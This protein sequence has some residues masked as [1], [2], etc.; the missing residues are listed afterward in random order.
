MLK[1]ILK[2]TAWF[3]GLILVL[4]GLGLGILYLRQDQIRDL[5]F[6]SLNESL[7]TR[8]EVQQAGA[9][10]QKF[11]NAAI[12]LDGVWAE[13]SNGLSDTLFFVKHLYVEFGILDMF[14]NEI[15]LKSISLEKGRVLLRQQGDLNNWSIL[16]SDNES[17]SASLKLEAVKLS[18]IA[19]AYQNEQV[20]L[21]GQVQKLGAKG[22]FQTGQFR[23]N[24]D[25]QSQLKRLSLGTETWLKNPLIVD[26]EM[27][28]SAKDS[29]KI[30]ARNL[31]LGTL[32]NLQAEFNIADKSTMSFQ[33]P[34]LD[35]MELKN[36]Y[37]IL[38]LNWPEHLKLAGY[39][40]LKVDLIKAP[41][42]DLRTE[43]FA[44]VQDLEL[45]YED[46][47][48]T[49]LEGQ[50]EYYRQGPF[51]RLE[52]RELFQN[53][54]G[55]ELKGT[56]RQLQKPNIKLSLHLDEQAEFWN[57]FLPK[58]WEA[59][60]GQT[61]VDLN[62]EG[63]FNSW[64]A[65][66]SRAI[67]QAHFAG[68]LKCENLKLVYQDQEQFRDLFLE[69]NLKDQRL[70]IDSLFL[71]RGQSD[72]NLKG[73]LLDIWTYL[74]DSL[75]ILKGNINLESEQF[76]LADFLSESEADEAESSLGLNWKKRLDLNNA[77]Q[78]HHF[79]FRNFKA[80]ELKGRIQLNDKMISGEHIS[81]YA[82][83]GHY[84]GYFD[85]LTPEMSNYRFKAHLKAHRVQVSSV[86]K[87][88]DNFDQQTITGNNLEGQLSLFARI[89][90]PINE[91]LQ[92]D[93]KGLVALAEMTIE[94]G[95]LRNYEPMQALSRFAEVEELKDVSFKTLSN[96]ITI[97]EGEIKIPEMAIASNVLNLD[98]SGSHSFENDIDYV[99]KMRLGDVLFAKRDKQS[100][101]KEFE[102]HLEVSKRDDD[103][104]IPI[105]ISGTVDHPKIGISRKSLGSSLKESLKKQGQDLRD[106]FKKKPKEKEPDTGLQFEW[107]EG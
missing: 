103:H 8:I 75:S 25:L 43:V 7:N 59:S 61:Q 92:L 67:R 29:L 68:D 47:Q 84:E 9:S 15:P 93:S 98:L 30:L 80:K 101:N 74:S 77:I 95:R 105:H 42:T 23:L 85:L 78:F 10:L 51:D 17:T 1:R 21:R 4:I 2:I 52:I 24:L 12:R 60:E 48:L 20:F 83:E 91:Q 104:R 65:I 37:A 14:K 62:F 81:L 41:Q 100:A 102:E 94:R 34:K 54:R 13:G 71:R 66:T 46:Y 45:E 35:L 73:E 39:S 89:E 3:T 88:F 82:D 99:I 6:E 63:Q 19:Y 64:D 22:Q 107:D 38:N 44:R 18:D 28:I 27:A 69:S 53:D 5:V 76:Y 36:I 33:H 70:L 72:L 79:A 87:S 26:A 56:I 86:F 40:A 96:T 11:P 50:L 58:E 90:A 31:R 55:L 32:E 97:S 49:E 57:P 106:L 16:K